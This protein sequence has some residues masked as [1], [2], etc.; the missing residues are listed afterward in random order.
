MQLIQLQYAVAVAQ[1]G[2]ITE[3]AKSLYIAQPNLSKALKELEEELGIL[4]FSRTTRGVVPTEAGKRFLSGAA[5]ILQ[6][7]EELQTITQQR[8]E[9]L[10][11]L[12][13][14]F[15]PY[16][17]PIPPILERLASM[18]HSAPDTDWDIAFIQTGAVKAIDALTGGES[19][20]AVLC[21][22]ERYHRFFQQQFTKNQFDIH[23][24]A[25]QPFYLVCSRQHPLAGQKQVNPQQL[26][27]LP[28]LMLDGTLPSLSQRQRREVAEYFPNHRVLRCSDRDLAFS[29]LTALPGSFLW[30]PP[31]SVPQLERYGLSQICCREAGSFRIVAAIPPKR[32]HSPAVRRF[33]RFITESMT[34]FYNPKER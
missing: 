29:T 3:A 33:I 5:E 27:G 28:R 25:Q 26:T 23:P 20:L 24:L 18:Q 17:D 10:F 14:T 30:H 2:S 8:G 15:S 19:E 6:K 11:R 34:H 4:I 32:S 21:Y 7:M 16:L 12:H 22:P 31:M 9:M 13:I 1:H